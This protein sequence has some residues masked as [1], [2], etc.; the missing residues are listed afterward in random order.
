MLEYRRLNW[1]VETSARIWRE[2]ED[3]ILLGRELDL[4]FTL[5]VS[6]EGAPNEETIQIAVSRANTGVVDRKYSSPLVE[7]SQTDS[8]VFE[9]GGELVASQSITGDVCFIAYPRRSDRLNP[10]KKELIL[11]HPFDP[12]EVTPC[13]IKKVLRRYLIVLQD[14]SFLGTEDA[15]TWSERIVLVW[16]Y[17]RELR[18]RHELYRSLLAM[19]NEWAKAVT[20]GVIAF[21]VG[22]LSAKCGT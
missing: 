17:F 20:A 19:R 8:P 7:P 10:E 14:S 1:K 4:P 2:F 5:R 3:F 16:L 12:V 9:T 11:F 13:L 21:V 15:L 6:R 22:Y 18:S